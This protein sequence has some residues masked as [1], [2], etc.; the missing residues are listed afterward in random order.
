MIRSNCFQSQLGCYALD[1]TVNRRTGYIV[2]IRRNNVG[3]LQ[4][5]SRAVVTPFG[6]VG[7]LVGGQ[8]LDMDVEV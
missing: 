8:C 4:G 3:T 5:V 7:C 6:I 2:I 1:M